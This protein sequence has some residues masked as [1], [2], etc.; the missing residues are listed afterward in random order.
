MKSRNERLRQLL[1]EADPA[2]DA[3]ELGA[4]EVQRLRRAMLAAAKSDARPRLARPAYAL[5]FAA[6]VA[7]VVAGVALSRFDARRRSSPHDVRTASSSRHADVA[8]AGVQ[9]PRLG[10]TTSSPDASQALAALHGTAGSPSSPAAS[11]PAPMGA[12][13]RAGLHTPSGTSGSGQHAPRAIDST[14]LAAIHPPSTAVAPSDVAPVES[15]AAVRPA[16]EPQ[17]PYQLQ[18]TAPGGTRIVWL[19]TDPS[20]R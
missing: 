20:G 18:L 19:L 17:Q 4:G 5:A 11:S 14:T 8:R 15:V 12:D 7:A 2:P 13:H 10:E 16:S 9:P 6:A 1:R 3:G